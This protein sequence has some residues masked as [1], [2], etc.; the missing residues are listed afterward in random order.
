MQRNTLT[1]YN[2]CAAVAVLARRT[3]NTAVGGGIHEIVPYLALAA[4]VIFAGCARHC[5]STLGN[6][7]AQDFV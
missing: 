7:T 3:F 6:L 5:R 4:L 1:V 2:G